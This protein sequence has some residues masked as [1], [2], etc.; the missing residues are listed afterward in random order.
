M[1]H[2]TLTMRGK[3]VAELTF[4]HSRILINIPNSAKNILR[5][6]FSPEG[7]D[8]R[9]VETCNKA[10]EEY[11]LRKVRFPKSLSNNKYAS[12][13]LRKNPT[14][15]NNIVYRAN[16]LNNILPLISFK[17]SATMRF[18]AKGDNSIVYTN[19]NTVHK[20]LKFWPSHVEFFWAKY[21][22]TH[23][24]TREKK[25]FIKPLGLRQ[26]VFQQVYEKEFVQ[27]PRGS[28]AQSLIING[29]YFFKICNNI[30]SAIFAM[31]KIGA[32]QGDLD[33]CNILHTHQGDIKIID[34]AQAEVLHSIPQIYGFYPELK[35]FITFMLLLKIVA[36]I[37]YRFDQRLNSYAKTYA[38]RVQH[39][40]TSRRPLVG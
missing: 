33:V 38:L 26:G 8:L 20:V 13:L 6:L 35:V 11:V 36:G 27:I 34:F 23:V 30:A 21:I 3:F 17:P 1:T 40:I 25:F 22:Y 14:N 19:T 4:K 10:L 2:A 18:L 39:E 7:F 15:T 31:F 29:P 24:L 5:T 9:A 28:Y 37:P 32:D 12:V 16:H